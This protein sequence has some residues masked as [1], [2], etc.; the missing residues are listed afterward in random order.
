MPGLA[1]YSS[2]QQEKASHAEEIYDSSGSYSEA[3][4]TA[5][6]RQHHGNLSRIFHWFTHAASFA[7]ICALLYH[8]SARSLGSFQYCLERF[9][10]YCRFSMV[11]ERD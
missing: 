11:Q 5:Q 6:G 7:I 2:L 10:A 8:A 3:E 1:A 4:W 9:N